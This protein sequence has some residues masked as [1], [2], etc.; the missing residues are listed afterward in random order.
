MARDEHRRRA[1]PHAAARHGR[2]AGPGD[3]GPV[4]VL[5]EGPRH[6]PRGG[7]A[8]SAW[9]RAARAPTPPTP[10]SRAGSPR[11]CRRSTPPRS[12]APTASGC[13]RTA[14]R[15]P[16]RWPAASCPTRSRTTTS[17]RGSSA[18]AP[19]SSSTT[20][21]SAGTR[22]EAI[23]P[24]TQRRKVTLAWNDEDLDQAARRHPGRGRRATS[25]S[26]CRTPTTGRRTSTRSID[27]DG[28]VIGASLFTGYS[29]N[30]RKGLSLATV[31]PERAARRRGA[32]D[33]GRAGR[34]QQEDDRRAARAVRGAR[35]REPGAVRGDR[36]RRATTA[37]GG[38]RPPADPAM[39][40][41]GGRARPPDPGRLRSESPAH[42]RH[43]PSR[44][45]GAP[46]AVREPR[47]RARPSRQPGR[48][49]AE[50]ELP[51]EHLPGEAR[52]HELALRAAVVGGD[53]R[54]A[55]PVPP[56]DGPVHRGPRRAAA[57]QRPRPSTPSR[58]SA[59][60]RP[61]SSSP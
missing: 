46:H 48:A 12:C 41:A 26:T 13:R 21:S 52:V 30:E 11:R 2:R 55:R 9:S 45:K 3:L 59:S 28:T 20:T 25:S 51:A 50:P 16:T 14:T 17:T 22:C 29:A 18:T 47:C 38:A 35:H 58:T 40:G 37:A 42:A 24:D 4:R 39:S 5:R 36:P 43:A 6:H 10:S 27:A 32:G 44:S 8:S 61:S 7:R 31:D 53:L 23:D 57:A 1:G 34:R 19:S 49:P 15:R 54:A 60:A 33:L 56:H